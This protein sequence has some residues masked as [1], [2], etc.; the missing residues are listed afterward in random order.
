MHPTLKHDQENLQQLLDQTSAVAYEFL[1]GINGR[2]PA[3]VPVN[4]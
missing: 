4:K 2:S 1:A 3:T